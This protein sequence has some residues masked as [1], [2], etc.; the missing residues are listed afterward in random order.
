MVDVPSQSDIQP[1]SGTT[2]ANGLARV[3]LNIVQTT[4]DLT[5]RVC[6]VMCTQ[7]V[8]ENFT[9]FRL[10]HTFASANSPSQVT[11]YFELQARTTVQT[12]PPHRQAS[13][14]MVARVHRLQSDKYIHIGERERR[15]YF[16]C[17]VQG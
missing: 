1:K 4:V 2:D 5:I 17:S 13:A 16:H 10:S 8:C 7:R 14:N 9:Q 11:L 6:P 15:K 12:L 3:T